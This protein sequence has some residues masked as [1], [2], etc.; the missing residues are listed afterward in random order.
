VSFP[1]LGSDI[2]DWWPQ[3]TCSS[4][5]KIAPAG[6]AQI[7]K[8]GVAWEIRGIRLPGGWDTMT[9][10]DTKYLPVCIDCIARLIGMRK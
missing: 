10:A 5:R 6:T 2:P 3:E 7:N 9:V 8:S 1:A 4:C